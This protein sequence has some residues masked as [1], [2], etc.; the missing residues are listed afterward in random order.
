M[1]LIPLDDDTDLCLSGGAE[2]ADL[3]WGMCAGLAGH[4]V[5]HWSFPNHRSHAPDIELVKLDDVQLAEADEHIKRAAKILK[6]HPPKQKFVKS[7]IQRNWYQVAWSKS[8]YAVAPI[9][10]GVVQGGTAWAVYMYL[11]KPGLENP[12]CY[13]Y[14][15][16]KD[17]W[18]KWVGGDDTWCRIEQPPKPTG[19]WAGI[20]TRELSAS[21]KQA[22][23]SLMGY[24]KPEL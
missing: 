14:D 6:K 4:K 22:I 23:R 16:T 19:I 21:G 10:D 15:Q 5:I 2:G 8:V 18:F 20:G 11:T 17:A 13:V 7:L 9:V 24:V 1:A 12:E 3:Q